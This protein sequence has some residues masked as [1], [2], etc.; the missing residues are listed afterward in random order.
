[1]SSST[2]ARYDPLTINLAKQTRALLALLPSGSPYITQISLASSPG[3]L[4]SIL[5]RLLAKPSLTVTISD[6]FRPLLIDL[7]ARWLQDEKDIEERF[8][9]LCLLIEYHDEL[10]PILSA[11]LRRPC[12][13]RGPLAFVAESSPID[14]IDATRLHRALLAYYRLLHANRLLPSDLQWPVSPISTLFVTPHPDL[15]V[16][17]LAIRCYALHTGMAEVERTKLETRVLGELGGIDLPLNYGQNIDESEVTIDGWLLPT[18]DLQRIHDARNALVAG[19]DFYSLEDGDAP[20][21]LSESDISPWIAHIH[22]MLMFKSSLAPP[23]PSEV[24]PTPSAINSLR[25]LAAHVSLRLPTLI[26]SPASSGKSLFLSHL[27]SVLYPGVKD[28][29]VT[30]HLADSSLDPRSLLGSYVSSATQ[31]GTFEWKDGVVVRAMKE[32]KWLVL[33]DIDRGSMEVLGLL[34]PLAESLGPGNWIGAK[35][36]IE[37]PNRGKVT[38]SEHFALFATRSLAPSIDGKFPSPTFYGSRKFYEVVVSAPLP[39]EV[40]MIIEARFPTLGGRIASAI[41]RIWSDVQQLGVTASS[42]P[43]GLREL[44]KFCLRV[45]NMFPASHRSPNVGDSHTVSFADLLP[46]PSVREEMYLE[47]RDVFFGAGAHSAPAQAH[48]ERIAI[49]IADHLGL[50]AERRKWVLHGRAPT[51]ETPKDV[52]GDIVCVNVG[53]IRLPARTRKLKSF[54]FLNRPFAMHKP[55]VCLLSRIATAMSLSEPVLL[56]GETGTGKTSAIT[57]LASLLN[58][59]LVSLNLS[60]QTESSDLLGGFKPIDAR[61]PAAE[62]HTRFLELFGDTFSRK[63]NAKFEDSIRKAVQEGRWRRAV[64]LWKESVRLAKERIASRLNEDAQ[65]PVR[66]ATDAEGPRKRRRLDQA[67]LQASQ[68][69]WEKFQQDVDEFDLQ[70]A[71]GQGKFAFDFVEGPLVKALRFGD[72]ILLDEINLASS[73]TLECITGLLSGAMASITLTEKGS[74]EAVPRHPDFRLFACM[75]PATDVGKKDLPPN[76]R[77]RFTEIDVP[78]PDADRE[79]LLSIINQYIGHCAV[80]DKAAIMNVAEFYSAVKQL[81]EERQLADG[82]NHRPHYSM[83]TLARALTFAADIAPMYGLRRALWEGCLMTFTMVLDGPSAD[84]V[85]G[86]SRKYIL[87]GVRNPKSLLAKEPSHPASRSADEFVKFGPFYLEK[88]ALPGDPMDDYIMTPSVERKLIDLARIALTRRFPVLIEGPTSSGKT[89]AVEYL[90]RRTGHQFIR[91]NNHE[92][93]DIQEYIGSYVS[94]AL[95]GKLSFRDGLLVNALRYGHWI[96]L[97]ELNLAPTDVLE[98]LN[99]LLD[100]NRE[101]VIPE[102]QEVVRPHPHFMLFATQN[103]PGLYAGRKVL[104]RAFRNRFLEVHFQDVPQAELETILCQRCR[105]APSYG[106]RIVAVFRELQKRRQTGRVFESKQGFATLR[107]L[108]RWA[109]RDAVGYQ[110]LAENGF[111]LLAERTRHDDD[112]LV[113]KEVIESVMKVQ[114]DEVA[115]YDLRRPDVESYIGCPVSSS[116]QVVWTNAMQRLFILVSRA[117]RFNEPVLLVGE[118]GSGKTSVCQVYSDALSRHL[119]ALSCHQNTETADLIGGLRP[120]RNRASSSLNINRDARSFLQDAG[121]VD[122]PSDTQDLLV[123]INKLLASAVD[124]SLQTSLRELRSSVLKSESLFEWHD[125]PLIRAMRDGDVFLLDEISLADDSVLERLNSVLEPDR[126]IVLAERGGTDGEYPVVRAA[127]TFKLVATMNPGGD[128]GKKELSPA[129]RNRF[130]E[131]WVPPLDSPDDLRMIVEHSWKHEGLKF[132][133]TPLLQFTHWLRERLDDRSVCTLRDILAWITFSNALYV[134][135]NAEMMHASEI[136]YHAAHMTVLDGLGSLPQTATHSQ[137]VLRKIKEEAVHKLHNV[138]PFAD[139]DASSYAYDPSLFIQVGP[140]AIPRGPEDIVVHAFNFQAPTPR[141]NALRVVRACQVQKPILLE[142]SPGVG[143]TSL[144]TALAKIAG[145]HLCRINLSDQTDLIDLFGSDLPVENGAPGEFAWRDAEFLR[146]MQH[147]HWVLL[148]E[149]NLA[150][151]AVLEGLNAI[152]DHRGMVY[153]PELGRSFV[154]HPSFR[155]F[156]AQNP[157]HQGGGRKGLPKSFLDRFT[158]VYVEELSADDML[159]VC[160]EQYK[161]CDDNVLRAMITFNARLNQ[162]VLVKRT[163]G[164]EGSP[165]EFN[166]R[167]ILRWGELMRVSAISNQPRHFV[168]TIYL[169]RFRNLGDRVHAQ[170]IFNELFSTS[171]SPTSNIPYPVVS[172]SHFRIGHFHAPR[173]NVTLPFRSPGILQCHLSAMEAVGVCLSRSWL[174]VVTGS[175]GSG[176]SSL[177]RSL[178]DLSGSTLEEV[179]ITSA[180]DTTDILGGFEQVNY[181]GRITAV[182]QEILQLSETF[183]RSIGGVTAG[184]HLHY[185]L[186]RELNSSLKTST[187][188][189]LASSN[190]LEELL[191]IDLQNAYVDHRRLDLR[192]RVHGLCQAGSTMGRFEWI[193]GP[194]VRAMKH[195]HWLVLDGANMC[196]PSVLDR[197]NSL[198]EPNGV[199]VLSERGFVDGEVQVLKPHPNFRLYMTVDPQYGELS[200]AMRNRGLEVSLLTSFTVEDQQRILAHCRLPNNSQSTEVFSLTNYE[201]IRR[202]TVQL[203]AGKLAQSWAPFSLNHDSASSTTAIHAPFLQVSEFVEPRAI[204]HFALRMLPPSVLPFIRR[205]I[206]TRSLKG[207]VRFIFG[208]RSLPKIFKILAQRL[209]GVTSSAMKELEDILVSVHLPDGASNRRHTSCTQYAYKIQPLDDFMICPPC[210][211]CTEG[212]EYS[213][214]HIWNLQLL[215]LFAAVYLDKTSGVVRNKSTG[216]LR[217][218]LGQMSQNVMEA[219]QQVLMEVQTTTH[220]LFEKSLSSVTD[221]SLQDLNGSLDLL[222]LS[223]GIRKTLA[224]EIFDHSSVYV[225]SKQISKVLDNHSTAYDRIASASSILTRAISPSSGLGLMEIWSQLRLVRPT[226]LSSIEIRQL[227]HATLSSL[228]T[229]RQN[230]TSRQRLQVLAVATLP[231]HLKLGGDTELNNIN[232]HFSSQVKQLVSGT[233]EASSVF[234]GAANPTSLLV[235]LQ[236][237]S[238][239]QGPRLR[240]AMT[241]LEQLAKSAVEQPKEDLRRFASYQHLMWEHNGSH[242][243]TAATVVTAQMQWLEALWYQNLE[244]TNAAN[245]PTIIFRP[246]QLFWSLKKSQPARVSLLSLE[247]HELSVQRNL[248]LSALQCFVNLSRLQQLTAL[249][250]QNVFMLASCFASTFDEVTLQRMHTVLTEER[251]DVPRNLLCLLERTAFEPLR[252]AVQHLTSAL[253]FQVDEATSPQA[254]VAHLGR[255]WVALSRVLLELLVPDVPIDPAA[256]VQRSVDYA[257][258]RVQFL[259]QQVKLHTQLEMRTAGNQTNQIISYLNSRIDECM[260]SQVPSS[261]VPRRQSVSSLHA[262]WSEVLHFMGQVVRYSKID[263]LTHLLETRNPSGPSREEVVQESIS[264]FCQRME[265]LHSEFDDIARILHLA[266]LQLRLGLRLIRSAS[267]QDLSNTAATELVTRLVAF[268]STRSAHLLQSQPTVGTDVPVAE[269]AILG[270]AAVTHSVQSTVLSGVRVV[271]TIYEQI[272]RLWTIDRARD[273]RREQDS[274]SLYRRNTLAHDAAAEAELDEREF[275]ELFPTF[276]EAPLPPIHADTSTSA[277][278]IHHLSHDHRRQL[279]ALHLRLTGVRRR[280][281]GSIPHAYFDDLRHAVLRSCIA[282]HASSLPD[283]VD[284]ISLHEQLVVLHAHLVAIRGTSAPDDKS[285]SFYVDANILEARKALSVV[286]SLRTRLTVILREWPDQMVLQHLIDKCDVI[287]SFDFTSPLAKFLSAIEQ[288]LMQTEDWEMYA[289]RENNLKEHQHTLT[290]LVIEW[291]RLELS[292]WKA[293]L[294]SQNRSFI[295]GVADFWFRLYEVL[296]RGPLDAADEDSNGDDGGLTAYLKQLPSLLDDFMRSSSLGQFEARLDLLRSFEIFID[297]VIR[298]KS[299]GQQDALRRVAR[300]VHSSWRY[301]CIFLPLISAS[302]HSQRRALEKEVE[303]LIKLASW[304]DVNIQALK[305]S[306]KKTHVQLYKI[307]RKFRDVLRQPVVDKMN[308]SFAGDVGAAR[309]LEQPLFT[310]TSSLTP[311]LGGAVEVSSIST[312]LPHLG[313]LRQTLDKFRGFIDKRV[314]RFLVQ[315]TAGELEQQSEDI[316]VTARDL[317]SQT[318]PTGLTK[319]KR[320]K[321]KKNL[322]VRKR[323]AWSDLQRDLKRAGLAYNIKPEVLNQLRDDCWIREQPLIPADGVTICTERGENFFDRLRGCLPILRNVLSD[324]HSDLN[325]RDLSRGVTLVESGYSLAIDTRS[326]LSRALSDYRTLC[327]QIERLRVLAEAEGS[328][329]VESSGQLEALHRALS[330]SAQALDELADGMQLFIE[331]EEDAILVPGLIE[332]CRGLGSSTRML[333]DRVSAVLQVTRTVMP[334]VWLHDEYAS[335]NEATSHL[336]DLPAQ[337]QKMSALCPRLTYILQPT[338]QWIREQGSFS[339]PDAGGL[340]QEPSSSAYNF[341]IIN[342]LLI[343]V[344]TLLKRC[345]DPE[346][347]SNLAEDP[348]PSS[349]PEDNYIRRGVQTTTTFT[350]LLDL[351]NLQSHLAITTTYLSK[352]PHRLRQQCLQQVL[353]FLQCFLAFSGELLES[354][355]RWTGAL[356]KLDYVLCS[357][358][359]TLGTKGFCIPPE[360]EDGGDAHGEAEKEVGGT[361]LGEGTGNENVSKEIEDESQVEGLKGDDGE[362]DDR[363]EREQGTEENTIEMSED[364]GGELEDVP[365]TGAEEEQEGQEEQEEDEE[366][367]DEQLG[368]LDKSDPGLVDEK[369]WGDED[370]KGDGEGEDELRQDRSESQQKESDIVAKEPKREKETKSRDGGNQKENTELDREKDSAEVEEDGEVDEGEGPVPEEEQEPPN[371]SGAPMDEHIPD[372]NTLD[373]PEDMNL[374]EEKDKECLDDIND[375]EFGEEEQLHEDQMDEFDEGQGD[376]PRKDDHD[377]AANEAESQRVDPPLQTEDKADEAEDDATEADEDSGAVARPDLADGDGDAGMN[378]SDPRAR[379]SA[380]DGQTSTTSPNVKETPSGGQTSPESDRGLPETTNA[381]QAQTQPPPPSAPQAQATPQNPDAISEGTQDGAAYPPPF[382]PPNPLRNLGDALKEVQQRFDEIFGPAD[383]R[384]PVSQSNSDEHAEQVEYAQDEGA[385]D[386]MQALG[387]A[388]EEQVAKLREL[389]LVD[390]GMNGEVEAMDVDLPEEEMKAA[391]DI[392]ME[393]FQVEKTAEKMAPDIEGAVTH[394]KRDSAVATRQSPHLPDPLAPKVSEDQDDADLDKP[395]PADSVFNALRSYMAHASASA[396]ASQLWSMYTS[397]TAPLS[398]ALCESLRL[399]LAPTQATRLRGDFRTGKRLNMRRVIGWVASEYTKDRIWMRRVK[400]SGREYQVLLAVDDSASMRNGN[401]DGSGGAVHLAYQTVVLVV[402]ALGKLEVGEVGVAR[403]GDGWELIRGFGDSSGTSSSSKDWGSSPQEGGRVLSSFAFRDSRTDVASFLEGSLSVLE[404]AREAS[405]SATGKDLWQLEIIISDGICQDHERMRRALRRAKGMKVLVVF[406][407]IDALN[408]STTTTSVP[409]S[410]A[411]TPSSDPSQ[412]SILTLNQVSYKVSP[413]TGAMELTMERYLD[414]FPFEYYVVLR[415]VEAL[416]RVLADTLREFFERI[417][418]E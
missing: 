108:F 48:T 25:I 354:L 173:L 34:K 161:E 306:A 378:E 252:N 78:P 232:T 61:I 2:S 175:S 110:E 210:S 326:A 13:S 60:H 192:S 82:S 59:S 72:W 37:V 199:L 65:P 63:K 348:A 218:A 364:F 254:G 393:Q 144:I 268:P 325:T 85:T 370:G 340:S 119:H 67:S 243:I 342:A 184:H 138:V 43:I 372:A 338:E 95:T 77:A 101:L 12:F 90:A 362:E 289:H 317:A 145:H 399:I 229:E 211:R 311:G 117:L 19:P 86:L 350:T 267:E 123:L 403:F 249:F 146:A 79:T 256:M 224:S 157:L 92:H 3:D 413:T 257:Q 57:H 125:G 38:A 237:L 171:D 53:R 35:A 250:N 44:E 308:P 416:P 182:A 120:V 62:L 127:E 75:N 388:G 148:D 381:N 323:K 87:S 191:N 315:H 160:R 153:I 409:G 347:I 21:H 135:D 187:S 379:D 132:L 356:F 47:A 130:T 233:F 293:L 100:D 97:D 337:L 186:Q 248:R 336:I 10:F 235:E 205:Y 40:K 49:L 301:F 334:A 274:N 166:L 222:S 327:P 167:D 383:Q 408:T 128:Y 8:V 6:L 269:L 373:L 359:H 255:C 96:V 300:I 31:L 282:S 298:D 284:K 375:E 349:E 363:M 310:G 276:E 227:G 68:T 162:E 42:R 285:P 23:L 385:E 341:N 131:I 387:P 371:A 24:I 221:I 302:L 328:V 16:R 91:I 240:I 94:D 169:S 392:A 28:H 215:D 27:A 391:P 353:P 245:S 343:T 231:A 185:A 260:K 152:L 136:F 382:Q 389:K 32:G 279:L 103:P 129:L 188:I 407:I 303:A 172:D 234:D 201:E 272:Y 319:E 290:S 417:T 324:H 9:A 118:T 266:L 242:D 4:L 297:H 330:C 206:E 109:G 98:A 275:L 296:I 316:M 156:A 104:S 193:D 17:Y 73:E 93:T 318:I 180:T 253:Q 198:C 292:C 99:R 213:S 197:L 273:D 151:Q 168:R 415:D 41:I 105:I 115:L 212:S 291:R 20:H 246:T 133:T 398:L 358:V 223:R 14:T 30:V 239:F 238:E 176:K 357:V 7:F 217:G 228:V 149:M 52:N 179:H 33:E 264:G 178:A 401:G 203:L 5:S 280:P 155:V 360:T 309:H 116:S 271:A 344:Q 154:R 230:I 351:P 270:V 251:P 369:L 396:S 307:V 26:T 45:E 139:C 114:I 258:E 339:F 395:P 163:F 368:G 204:V 304:K 106:Q 70:H 69:A 402:Q 80:G 281:P 411:P 112:K 376:Q 202:G 320:E 39:E 84:V 220:D 181:S 346:H 374:D 283:F 244:R 225:L 88:G 113:V 150:P 278:V 405:S 142:G 208:D 265:T 51:F 299:G 404:A 365:D 36:T 46:S 50:D 361:G 111:M 247:E 214:K 367:P 164:R 83:R 414:S 397:L 107:D 262:F 141:E 314:R 259:T 122:V 322:L 121:V 380:Q 124:I 89:S 29:I 189:L 335:I 18:L 241:L 183:M 345:P 312:S 412:S 288:L 76:I 287:L 22:G 366:E 333:G 200:R 207:P 195:G 190:L 261:N 313:N 159:V 418:E 386:E 216:Q 294:E 56:T 305:Q 11:F 332:R 329:E 400:P 140:F 277:K 102:T 226:E 15:G 352:F 165:W 355:A 54:P 394:A 384:Q 194:L 406:I 219:L 390:E 71:Q 137:E 158:K 177:I 134:P 170:A 66:A 321:Y 126:T 295:D 410:S 286:Q 174:V 64:T 263:D 147:G 143:K 81:A 377:T 1:M 196:N 236:A 74:L 209:K 58:R 331:I 55:A